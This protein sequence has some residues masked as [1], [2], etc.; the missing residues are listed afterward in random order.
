M[1]SR[2]PVP[3]GQRNA[4]ERA[5]Y[6]DDAEY[7]RRIDLCYAK[8]M[9]R[10]HGSVVSAGAGMQA[11]CAGIIQYAPFPPG[12]LEDGAY[13]YPTAPYPPAMLRNEAYGM[14][15]APYQQSLHDP[16]QVRFQ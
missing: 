10:R 1:I 13:G 7:Q 11:A 3:Y 2:Q 16:R 5:E 9:M 12:M 15:F 6:G 4:R 14:G 8:Q